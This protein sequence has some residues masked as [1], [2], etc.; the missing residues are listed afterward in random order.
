MKQLVVYALTTLFGVIGTILAL[1][2]RPIVGINATL[3]VV[4]APLAILGALAF[5]RGLWFRR[6]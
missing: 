5:M 4:F 3:L 1:S 2:S 6:L